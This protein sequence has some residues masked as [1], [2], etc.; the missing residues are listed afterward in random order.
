[1]VPFAPAI[2]IDAKVPKR[3]TGLKKSSPFTP[4]PPFEVCYAEITLVN[5]CRNTIEATILS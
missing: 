1:M 2:N 5:Y 4:P 3:L